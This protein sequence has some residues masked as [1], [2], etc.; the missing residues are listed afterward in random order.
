MVDQNQWKA[1]MIFGQ[2]GGWNFGMTHKRE[3]FDRNG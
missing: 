1:G 3:I 2:N